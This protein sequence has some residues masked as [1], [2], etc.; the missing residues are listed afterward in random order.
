MDKFKSIKQNSQI[1]NYIFGK[2]LQQQF[3]DLS[4][5]DDKPKK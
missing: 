2:T 3:T 4:V 1:S 5:I